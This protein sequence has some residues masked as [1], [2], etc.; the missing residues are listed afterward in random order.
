MQKPIIIFGAGS[1]GQVVAEIFESLG[2]MVYGFLDDNPDI[3]ASKKFWSHN[4]C[5]GRTDDDHYLEILGDKC[6]PFIA[7]EKEI[8][9][10]QTRRKLEKNNRM[11]AIN[12]IHKYS[13]LAKEV[14][15]GIGNIIDVGVSIGWGTQISEFCT[16]MGYTKIG[17]EV[18][19]HSFA[20]IDEGAIIHNNVIVE[21]GVHIGSGAIIGPGVIVEKKSIIPPGKIIFK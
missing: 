12:A 20:K 10:K 2:T 18:T 7:L 1:R 4:Q 17:K 6:F 3:A 13:Y 15:F 9:I 8:E 11:R 19:I 21:E 16:L 5:L 14:S